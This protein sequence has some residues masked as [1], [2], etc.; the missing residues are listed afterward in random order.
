MM[1]GK[2]LYGLFFALS[3]HQYLTVGTVLDE[4]YQTKVTGQRDYFSSV[5]YSLNSAGNVGSQSHH[6]KLHLV[7][8][9]K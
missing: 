8:K 9:V 1:V 7:A 6:D 4:A 3:D 5:T 2:L